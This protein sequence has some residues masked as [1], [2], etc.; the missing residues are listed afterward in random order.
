MYKRIKRTM[1]IMWLSLMKSLPKSTASLQSLPGAQAWWT[2]PLES[3]LYQK[4]HRTLSLP[5]RM[6]IEDRCMKVNWISRSPNPCLPV[7]TRTKMHKISH[8]LSNMSRQTVYECA[9]AGTVTTWK[10]RNQNRSATMAHKT[11]NNL[12]DWTE[13]NLP[14]PHH[15]QAS[16]S[17]L[18]HGQALSAHTVPSLRMIS[19]KPTYLSLLSMCLL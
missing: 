8:I 19:S 11:L 1:S 18:I 12:V 2:F 4:R 5:L 6:I 3:K 13:L 10:R 17:L 9:G 15:R 14:S 7:Q 16:T